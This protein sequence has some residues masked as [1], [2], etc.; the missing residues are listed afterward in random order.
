MDLELTAAD[1]DPARQ[2]ED[3][4]FLDYYSK[5]GLALALERYGFIEALADRGYD[6]IEIDT[7]ADDERHTLVIRSSAHGVLVELVVRRDCL[8]V[9]SPSGLPPVEPLDALT[10]DWLTLRHPRG[11]FSEARPRLPGQDAPGLGIGE[12]VLELLYRATE[13]LGLATLA[14]VPDH[15]HN[16]TLYARELPYVD[17][18]C[19]GELRALERLLLDDNGLSLAQASWAVEW[20]HVRTR[21]GASFVWKG[22]LMAWPHASSLR[23]YFRHRAYARAAERAADEASFTLEREAFEARWSKEAPALTGAVSPS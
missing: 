9:D 14:T 6:A 4:R 21:E 3:R 7:R 19:T 13:R 2:N 10:I 22:E 17:P 16:A 12:R 15:F 1:V 20:G 11:A 23:R 8:S 18:A 5:E